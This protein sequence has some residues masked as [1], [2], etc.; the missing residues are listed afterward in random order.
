MLETSARTWA[1]PPGRRRRG[2]LEPD[3]ALDRLDARVGRRRARLRLRPL[4]LAHDSHRRSP[5][6]GSRPRTRVRRAASPP[7]ARPRSPTWSR[8][9]AITAT[10]RGARPAHRRGRARG[11][12]DAVPPF[13][14]ADDRHV[15]VCMHLRDDQATT[16]SFVVDLRADA[17]PRAWACLGSPCASVFV[18]VLPAARFRRSLSDP[19]AVA[20]VRPPARPGREPIRTRSSAVAARA[21]AGRARPLGR[22]RRGR[23]RRRRT[24]AFAARATGGSTPRS[25]ASGSESTTRARSTPGRRHHYGPSESE[26]FRK[27]GHGV[28]PRRPVG[29]RGRHRARSRGTGLRRPAPDVRRGRRAGHPARQRAG[30]AGSRSRRPR[31]LLP[32]QLDR[33]PRGHDR[34]VQAPRGAD[35]RQLPLRRRRAA[36][37]AR[38]RRRERGRVPSRVRAEA[39]GDR[40]VAARSSHLSRGRRRHRGRRRRARRRSTTRRRSADASPDARLRPPVGRRSLHP[41]HRRNHRHAQGRHVAPRRRVLRRDGRRRR[42]RQADHHARGDRGALPRV[43]HPVRAGLPVH[44]RH[45]ALDGVQRA[46]HRRR[47]RDPG[48]APAR[49]AQALA[50]GRAGAGQLHGDRRRR[51][52]RARCSTRSTPTPAARSTSR[53]LRVLLSGGAILSPTLKRELVERL[54]GVLIVDG[55]GAS[56]TGGQGQSVVVSGGDIPTA[57]QFRVSDDTLVL[58][59]DLRPAP[60]GRDRPARARR[61]P[62]PL[63]YYKDPEKTAATFPVVDGVRWAVPGDH[64]VADADGLITLLGRG[65]GV[66]QHRR[67][68]GLPRRGRVG[69]EGPRRGDRRGRG[70]ASPTSVGANGSSRSCRR[71]PAPPRRSRR[72]RPTPASTSRATRCPARVVFVDAITRSPS[73]KPDYRW[74]KATALDGRRH[75]RT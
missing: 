71:G 19:G 17:P 43:A 16:A 68:E 46:V 58:G 41:L 15:T 25:S 24:R 48:R 36:L 5:T 9:S 60:A 1:A 69:A 45:R 33:V 23:R 42:R 11:R 70:R 75:E 53:G 2:D 57:P 32:L 10:G 7:A 73:G 6:T 38:R 13:H 4:A 59:E 47:G 31:R 40:A 21:R 30:R 14:D 67:R 74:A 34:R 52:R 49:R 35:Q 27:V 22:S 26:P 66:D 18:P 63:G 29:A 37:P 44:A 50:A 56:E 61:G 20:A 65:L 12:R 39:R 55:Y 54:P 28:Q 3:L 72:S 51:V 64:A 8:P 62:I